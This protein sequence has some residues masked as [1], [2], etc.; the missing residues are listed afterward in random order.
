M[1]VNRGPAG[2]LMWNGLLYIYLCKQT[3]E[4]LFVGS[5]PIRIH[6]PTLIHSPRIQMRIQ[7]MRTPLVRSSGRASVHHSAPSPHA[8]PVQSL[9]VEVAPVRPGFRCP[10]FERPDVTDSFRRDAKLCREP[11]GRSRCFGP[12]LIEDHDCLVRSQPGSFARFWKLWELQVRVEG[13]C[14]K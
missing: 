8:P 2:S 6:S 10:R 14:C 11:C 1:L 9:F 13:D 7:K 5:S 4:P 12:L 3:Q